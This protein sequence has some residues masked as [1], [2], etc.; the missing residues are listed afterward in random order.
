MS[1][2]AAKLAGVV[3]LTTL[4]LLGCDL[5]DTTAADQARL[6]AFL[7]DANA[8]PQVGTDLQ[9]NFSP[10]VSEY[11]G[12]ASV[13]PYWDLSYFKSSEQPF[14][15]SDEAYGGPHPDFANSSTIEGTISNGVPSTGAA[16][17]VFVADDN[18]PSTRLIRAIFID[19]GSTEEIRSLGGGQLSGT[20]WSLY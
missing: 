6:D 9:A 18:D 1:I 2:K 11:V 12:M 17:F 4:A 8:S 19:S 15:V 3:L 14:A 7:Q 10:D 20:D 16:V 5:L 13:D